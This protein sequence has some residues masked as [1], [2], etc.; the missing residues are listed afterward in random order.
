[1]WPTLLSWDLQALHQINSVWTHP[2]LDRVMAVAS[3]FAIFKIP[4]LVGI[5]ALLIWGGFRERLFLVLMLLCVLIGDTGI[6]AGLKKAVRR[7]RPLEYL[8]H[9]RIVDMNEIKWS[10]PENV[11]PGGR[12]FP[13]GHTFNNVAL[14]L[15]ATMLYGRWAWLLWPWAALVSYSR[16]YTGSHHPSDVLV[17]WLIALAFTSFILVAVEWSWKRWGARA[18]PKLHAAHPQLIFKPKSVS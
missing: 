11:K 9:V 15:V 17:S 4:L 5:L 14:A 7:P 16:V 13:S 3:S 2:V 6:D 18:F 12:S 1:M 10:T 8:Q